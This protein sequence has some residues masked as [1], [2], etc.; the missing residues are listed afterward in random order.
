[1]VQDAEMFKAEDEALKAKI[2]AR[3]GMES[4]CF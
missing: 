1:M 2:D 4:Y 3:N